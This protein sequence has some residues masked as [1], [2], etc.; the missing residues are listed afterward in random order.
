MR[1]PLLMQFAKWPERGRVKTRLAS[2]LG[3][4]GALEAHIT[5][6]RVVLDQLVA[7]GYPV[8]FWWDR[9]LEA[10]PEEASPIL[11]ELHRHDISQHVQEGEDLGARM[12]H[13][14]AWGVSS[15]GCAV[16]VGSDCPSVTPAYVEAALRALEDT[17]VVLG[18]SDDGGYVLIGART[19]DPEMLA[20]VEW[21]TPRALEQTLSQLQRQGLRHHCLEPRWD[22]DE[23]EDWARFVSA[24]AGNR[25]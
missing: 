23:P 24:G 13:A 21:G 9:W 11:A 16:I 3:E 8:T 2:T 25:G 7:T 5:L 19:T 18:P 12:A 1:T 10:P 20:G 15:A 17:D 4:T 6:T 22:V 14:L